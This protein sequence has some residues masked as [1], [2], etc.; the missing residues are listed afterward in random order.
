[1][2]FVEQTP[3]VPESPANEFRAWTMFLDA[4]EQGLIDGLT[5]VIA[6]GRRLAVEAWP[7]GAKVAV[8]ITFDVD[9]EFPM[10]AAL[11]AQVSGGSYGWFQA[12]PR[13]HRLL[14]QEE[15][16]A[17]FYV[18][19][20]SAL[21]GK[22]IVPDI[23]KSGRHEIGLH[24]WTH[25]RVPELRG[26]DEEDR[27]L[28]Q[29]IVWYQRN[30]GHM[31]RGYRAPNGAISLDTAHLLLK[32]GIKYDSSLPGGDDCF[33]LLSRGKPTGLVEV[34]FSWILTDWMYLHVDEF[35]QGNEQSPDEVYKIYKAEFDAAYEEGGLFMLTLH[36]HVIGRRSRLPV[37]KRIIE[38]AKAKGGVWF[39]TVNQ[40]A[41]Y[42][43]ERNALQSPR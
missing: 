8:A 2:N 17:T 30:V 19:V 42:V 3:T 28:S 41:E 21:L 18:P 32:A 24:G 6:T 12:L 13:I 27:L 43:A 39:A 14:D 4:N 5:P 36:P 20:G 31:P 25:E 22:E 9:N 35:Y 16:P 7:N 1:M 37:L 15:I 34:P 33:E 40:I 38:D 11:P 29:Q 26:P 23:L 10:A